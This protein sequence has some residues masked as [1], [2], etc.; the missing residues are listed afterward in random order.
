MR[1][2]D[3]DVLK[4]GV[5]GVSTHWLNEWSTLGVLA[6]VD[7]QTTVD[8]VPVVRCKDCKHAI[9]RSAEQIANGCSP[10]FCDNFV[11]GAYPEFF[12]MDGERKGGAD[13]V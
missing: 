4:Q 13:D 6:M 8:A 3:A 7:K 1:L 12:C 2:I 9:Q 10:L 11:F 5:N